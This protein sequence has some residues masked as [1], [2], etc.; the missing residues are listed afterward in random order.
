MADR[1]QAWIEGAAAERP[2][3]AAALAELGELYHRKLWHQLTVQLE[4]YIEQPEFQEGGFLVALYQNFVA[5]FAHKVN[6]LK[7]AFFAVAVGKQMASPEEGSAFI[8][9]VIANL[10][11]SKQPDTQQPILYL[12]MQL[13]QYALVQGRLQDCKRAFEAGREELD[14]LTDVDPQ[15]SASVYYAA[16]L[17]HKQQ[18]E[19]AQYYRATLMYLAYVSQDSLPQ[20]F[21]QALAVDI[22]LAALLGEDVYNFGELLLHPIINALKEGG[23]GWLL[24]MLE[25]FNSGNIHRYDE[26]CTRH[27][28]VLNG[29]P[30]LVAHERRLREKITILCLMELISSLP[31]DRRTIALSTVADCTKLPLDGV[32][33]LLM[34]TLALHLIEGVIDQVD[35]SVQVSWVQP[36]ILTLPQ[37][38]GLRARL[39]GWVDKVSGAALTLENEAVGIAQTS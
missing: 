11:A 28:V 31:P 26:L 30:A 25:C 1:Y 6:L 12:R 4:Q 36:R 14:G 19:Y 22:S 10:E 34:K 21:R 29:Q 38:E 32:E 5:G 9:D 17:Y 39:D 3:L 15:V 33:F 27:A 7:L 8:Q 13:A 18:K 23:F 20:D 16:S 24:E 35:G 2:Q 37:I